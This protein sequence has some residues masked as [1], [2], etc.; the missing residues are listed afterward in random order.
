[1]RFQDRFQILRHRTCCVVAARRMTILTDTAQI[2]QA[3]NLGGFFFSL[4]Y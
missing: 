2:L 4:F 1:M 3:N